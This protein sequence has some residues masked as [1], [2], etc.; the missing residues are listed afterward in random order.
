VL[1]ISATGLGVVGTHLQG[2]GTVSLPGYAFTA[3]T[4][5]GIY[6]IGANNIGVGVNGAKVLDIATTGLGVTGLIEQTS[7]SHFLIAAGTTAQ[8][9]SNVAGRM[10]YNSTGA[11]VEFA[12]G[13]NWIGFGNPRSYLAGLTLSNGTDATNDI[14]I[15]V[16]TCRNAANDGDI[17]LASILTK[18]LDAAWAV[19]TNAGG[20]DTGSIAN[21]TYHIWLIRRSD[22]GVVD[23]LFS[24]SASSPTMPTSY[25][26]KRRIGSIVRAGATI[27]AFTQNGDDFHLTT[28]VLDVNTAAP[29]TSAVTATLAS[30]PSGR[31]LRTNITMYMAN[32]GTNVY[33]SA[34]DQTDQA[35]STTAAPLFNV[36][37]GT[38]GSSSRTLDIW[39]NTSAQIRYR[40]S[41][42]QQIY[43][44]TNGWTDRRGRDD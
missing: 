19:G 37:D 44:V 6:R 5:S 22:T 34:L 25:D 18:Q 42:S 16:G 8:R 39:T 2:D 3:D 38:A 21:T 30:M 31:R 13:T 14:N 23:A 28:P 12:D 26:S 20:L 11:V 41:S 7:T 1:D 40:C 10:R 9:P 17:T 4:D 15:A 24:T 27:L 32:G 35:P 33:V 36:G 43:I 29:G